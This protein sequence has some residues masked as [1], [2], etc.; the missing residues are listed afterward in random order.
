MLHTFTVS[1]TIGG[2]ATDPYTVEA[3]TFD[4]AIRHMF[5][6]PYGDWADQLIEF[7]QCGPEGD[8]RTHSIERVEYLP[9][10]DGRN[11]IIVTLGMVDVP[12]VYEFEITEA[13]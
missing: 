11:R 6:L 3:D 1:E 8:Y 4:N 12:H 7:C 2:E 13:K 9:M 5:G 10:D